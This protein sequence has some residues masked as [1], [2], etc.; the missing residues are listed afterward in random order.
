MISLFPQPRG[1]RTY[2]TVGIPPYPRKGERWIYPVTGE[3]LSYYVDSNG[4]KA[5]VEFAD[6]AEW[7][8][9]NEASQALSLQL[10][11]NIGDIMI[12]GRRKWSWN[13]KFWKSIYSNVINGG[14]F[15]D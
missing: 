7:R 8:N 9:L 6:G 3:E 5:F 11:P 15:S 10:S 1:L 12:H 2:Q 14:T 13:G 4:R